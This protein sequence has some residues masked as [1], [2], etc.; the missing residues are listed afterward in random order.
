MHARPRGKDHLLG[1]LRKCRRVVSV[2]RT[3]THILHSGLVCYIWGSEVV[4]W[5]YMWRFKLGPL[6]ITQSEELA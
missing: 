5:G 6:I 3:W 1:R 4:K 2:V